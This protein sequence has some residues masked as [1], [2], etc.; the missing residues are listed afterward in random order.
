MSGTDKPRL[1]RG[2]GALLGED[3]LAEPPSEA[4]VKSLPVRKIVPNPFQPRR[5][6]G[7]EELADLSQS[8]DF[9]ME[10]SEESRNDTL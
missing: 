6:F 3:Y 4:E 9:K 1:G 8:I 5:D 10:N 2:L 7:A